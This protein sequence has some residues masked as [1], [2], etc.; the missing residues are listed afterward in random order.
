MN[1]TKDVG[2]AKKVAKISF[3]TIKD[4]LSDNYRVDQATDTLAYLCLK[5]YFKEII[6]AEEYMDEMISALT[7]HSTAYQSLVFILLNLTRDQHFDSL[8]SYSLKDSEKSREMDI[9]YYELKEL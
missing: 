5:H 4:A 3:K 9:T 8:P 7:S 6:L 2:E 1:E